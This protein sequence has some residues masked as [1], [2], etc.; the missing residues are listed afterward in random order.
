MPR[1]IP[2]RVAAAVLV[3]A[4]ACLMVVGWLAWGAATSPDSTAIDDLPSVQE[5]IVAQ[6]HNHGIDL[7]EL[8]EADRARLSAAPSAASSLSPYDQV[9][10]QLIVVRDAAGLSEALGILSE[11]ALASDVVA[12]ECPRLYADVTGVT[13]EVAPS[14]AEVCPKPTP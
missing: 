1:A 12:R 2:R 4:A 5:V 9:L 13:S 10:T 6:A 3:V 11:V 7:P 14:V 8:T